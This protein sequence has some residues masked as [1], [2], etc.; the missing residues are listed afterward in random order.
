ME[1]SSNVGSRQC[2]SIPNQTEFNLADFNNFMTNNRL[3]YVIRSNDP[4]RCGYRLLFGGRCL[5]IAS[6][7]ESIVA[8]VDGSNATIRLIRVTNHPIKAEQEQNEIQRVV[9]STHN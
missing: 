6:V 8:F 1:V 5:T 3:S 2:S 9:P 7:N 4:L